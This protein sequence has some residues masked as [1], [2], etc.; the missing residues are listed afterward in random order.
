MFGWAYDYK[1]KRDIEHGITMVYP[2]F[3]YRIEFSTGGATTIF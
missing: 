2:Y 3:T 1:E